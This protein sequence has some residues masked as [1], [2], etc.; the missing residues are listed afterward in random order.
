MTMVALDGQSS[1]APIDE[2]GSKHKKVLLVGLASLSAGGSAD[3]AQGSATPAWRR[4]SLN[5]YLS[6]PGR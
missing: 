3:A 6:R 5:G 2:T 4:C 1:G